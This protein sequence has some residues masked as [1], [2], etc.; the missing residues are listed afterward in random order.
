MMGKVSLEP[1][2]SSMSLIQALWDSVPL[3]LCKE[4]VYSNDTIKT[5]VPTHKS[6]Q[7]DTTSSELR[8]KLG[9]STELGGANGGEVILQ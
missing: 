6:N 3:A 2:T 5:A 1:V 4:S 8:L 9:E 7:L